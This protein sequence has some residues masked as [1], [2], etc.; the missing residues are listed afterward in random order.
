MNYSLASAR[1]IGNYWQKVI[2]TQRN[3]PKAESTAYLTS[4]KQ[5]HEVFENLDASGRDTGSIGYKGFTEF[6]DNGGDNN[7]AVAEGEFVILSKYNSTPKTVT[8]KLYGL[9]LE[10]IVSA[11]N[12][13]C[14]RLIGS[15]VTDSNNYLI[16]AML[17]LHKGE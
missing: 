8:I 17:D 10:N 5:W 9:T 12:S 15:P 6:D 16:S 14:E 13:N 3:A 7:G 11:L 1:K 4:L 2:T